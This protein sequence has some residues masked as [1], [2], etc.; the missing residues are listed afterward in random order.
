MMTVLEFSKQMGL[1]CSHDAF[2]GAYGSFNRFRQAVCYVIGGS[3]PPHN[4]DNLLLWNSDI[5]PDENQW[6]WGYGYSVDTH[7]GLHLFL[8]HSD[9]DGE[10]SPED[11]IKVAQELE[12]L[13][14]RL[15][16]LGMGHGHIESQGGYAA[17]CQK[18]VDGCKEAAKLGEP[19]VFA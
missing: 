15:K 2:H 5:P 3:Y 8:C 13:I 16:D 6:Y 4:K 19:L 1:D 9:C 14:P 7:P 10:I 11:C 12:I 18:F 17:V